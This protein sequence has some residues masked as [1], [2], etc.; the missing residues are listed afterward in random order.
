M[1]HAHRKE[2]SGFCICV[3]LQVHKL[4]ILQPSIKFLQQHIWILHSLV[5]T[6]FLMNPA[7]LTFSNMPKILQ[8]E[9]NL[10]KKKEEVLK[11]QLDLCNGK[12]HSK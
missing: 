6:L 3:W 12:E 1:K 11:N 8:K 10:E 7:V 2:N 9:K 4:N 5:Y